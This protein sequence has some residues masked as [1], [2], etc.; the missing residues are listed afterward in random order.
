M[1]TVF[2]TCS[3]KRSFSASAHLAAMQ[4]FFTGRTAVT[5]HLRTKKDHERILNTLSDADAVVFSMPL[6]VDGVPSHV[7]SF[8][9]VFEQYAKEHS[10]KC[11]VYAMCNNGYI[12]GRQGAPL[13]STMECFAARAGL[14]FGGGLGIGGGIMLNVLKFVFLAQIA[15]F[16]TEALMTGLLEGLWFPPDLWWSLLGS[17]LPIFIFYAGVVFYMVWMGFAIRALKPFGKRYTR[18]LLP[19]F[20]FVLIANIFLLLISLFQGGLFRGLLAKKV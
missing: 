17:L 6:Y 4:R 5:E 15:M 20:L 9:Q 16:L 13:L 19:N 10:L 3:P 11:T 7:L 18:L 1:K 2:V 8:L 12:E 14:P